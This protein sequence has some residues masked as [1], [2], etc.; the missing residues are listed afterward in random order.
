METNESLKTIFCLSK[1]ISINLSRIEDLP[2]PLFKT[3][4]AQTNYFGEKTT[5]G[6]L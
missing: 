4:C 5:Y 2:R 6:N 3:A 1:H